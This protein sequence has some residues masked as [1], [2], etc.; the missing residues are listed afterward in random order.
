MNLRIKCE[1]GIEV[2]LIFYFR[3]IWVRTASVSHVFQVFNLMTFVL[4][5]SDFLLD[6]VEKTR[7]K[8]C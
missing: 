8:V 3:G 2:C 1:E 5:F 6:Y 7:E 4:I